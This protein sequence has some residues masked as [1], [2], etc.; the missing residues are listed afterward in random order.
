MKPE[1]M[2]IEVLEAQT[3]N[4][5]D[6]SCAFPHGKL[7]VVTGVS[8]SG[9]SSLAFDTVYAEGQRRYVETLSTYARQFLQQMKKPPVR[10]VKNMPPALALRQ[11][12][13][14]SAARA[15]V[16]SISELDDYLPL[17]FA[18]V[19]VTH[20]RSCGAFVQDWT[21]PRVIDW[22]VEHADGE[23]VVVLGAIKPEEGHSTAELLRQLAAE[24]HRR[25]EVNGALVAIDAPEVADVLAAGKLRV[26]LDRLVVRADETRL[27]EA[28]EN[29]YGFGERVADVLLW[30]RR[31]GDGPAPEQRFYDHHRCTACDTL[32]QPPVPALF[33]TQST[34]GACD[35]CSGYGRTVGVDPNK[36]VPDARK[37]LREG[38]VACF[39]TATGRGF[40]RMLLQH[41]EAR[42]V[43]VGAPWHSLGDETQEW[44]MQGG[45]GYPGV[46]AFFD[47][48]AEDR[49]K[50]H[51]RI[52][53][54]R[55]RGYAPC[56]TCGG[57][58]LSADARA[59]TVDGLH[60]GDLRA[61][62]VERALEWIAR[63]E[64][65]HELALAMDPLLRGISSRLTYL[66][67][68]GVGYLTLNRTART[69]SGG[70]MHR[71]MLATNL[72]RMLTDT[73]YV[74]DEPTAGLHAHDTERLME[75]IERLRDVG[76]TVIVV[77]HD[78]DVIRR[79]AH[80]VEL[81]PGAGEHGGQVLFEGEVEALASTNTA[82]G[83]ML[84]A[85]TPTLV[86]EL[87]P[88]GFL[89]IEGACLHNLKDVAASF[90]VAH[91]SVVTG[92]SGSGK[93]TLVTDVLV[94]KLQE[95]RGQRGESALSSVTVHNDSFDEIVVVDQGSIARSSRSCAM[96][97]SGAYTPI[98]EQFANTSYAKANG[99]KAGA[100]SFNA[101][102]GRCDRCDG[103][104]V[105]AIEMHFMADVELPCDV[106]EGKR[107]KDHVL[108]ATLNGVS[109][110]DVFSMTVSEAS[111]FFADH[112]SIVRKLAPLERVGLGYV[113]LGQ[114]TSQM[115]G[116]E[117]QRL[118]LA[119][120]VGKSRASRHRRLFV[121]DEPTVG[122][123]LSDVERL[124][125]AL[126]ELVDEGN[127]VI[128]VEHNLDFVAQ[129]DWIVDLGPG[130]GEEGGRVLYEGPV[131]GV[132]DVEGSRTG[133]YLAKLVGGA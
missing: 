29:A 1:N 113:R 80:V 15:T 10:A 52:L 31:E 56:L 94:G 12:N 110:A 65:P 74:L 103:T 34:V 107:F 130:A 131:A 13:S 9:K 83:A 93:S 2:R 72:G 124:V 51:I 91:L 86:D 16:S 41:A 68:A 40:R 105:V 81:G 14:V 63:L 7:S 109:I 38:A 115:S 48:L 71:V 59:V 123:H 60:L 108:A 39:E 57:S 126:R 75:V 18:G 128:V 112:K 84:R 73:C 111:R 53:I 50:P 58:G 76:N 114:T 4:L 66:V 95:A 28:L 6:A 62:R 70:E 55:Y 77:E 11:G 69:L 37:S 49:Y 43:D 122:L 32:H 125:G 45:G 87:T 104:G 117:L 21:V 79:A 24:G 97:L 127:T 47:R 17:L 25:V 19:G 22:L 132:I 89:S 100:F 121:F 44:V 101:V 35:V 88:S 99:L 20:C 42:G 82:T 85:R 61:M 90:P 5:R 133:A 119:S 23:R 36:V 54:A 118:K 92:V 116:G 46:L 102:G 64:L 30:D 33:D 26:V 96:T 8:G 120:Y 106:C 3:H 129:C 67:D 78:P 98:R 27:S